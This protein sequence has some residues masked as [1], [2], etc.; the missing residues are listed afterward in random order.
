MPKPEYNLGKEDD[1][2]ERFGLN[3]D[4]DAKIGGVLGVPE[5]QL[6]VQNQQSNESVHSVSIENERA[7]DN[8]NYLGVSIESERAIDNNNYLGLTAASETTLKVSAKTKKHVELPA[9]HYM[10]PVSKPWYKHRRVWGGLFLI[11]IGTI[12]GLLINSNLSVN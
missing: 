11:A 6:Q 7:L 4:V 12:T 10:E 3:S 5:K 9:T 8:N 2:V 1:Q